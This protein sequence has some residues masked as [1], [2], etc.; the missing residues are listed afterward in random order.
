MNFQIRTEL[1]HLPTNVGQFNVHDLAE[2][3]AR[4]FAQSDRADAAVHLDPFMFVGE[5]ACCKNE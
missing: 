5:F 1:H 3:I 4:V 2:H